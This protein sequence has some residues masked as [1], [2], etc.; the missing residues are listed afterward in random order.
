MTWSDV[1]PESTF[2]NAQLLHLMITADRSLVAY[3]WVDTDDDMG[4]LRVAAWES[5]AGDRWNEIGSGFPDQAWPAS[6]AQGAQ[7]HV[8]LVVEPEVPTQSL[9]WSPDG[10]TWERVR[11]LGSEGAYSVGA[12]DEGFV[13]AGWRN[14][15]SQQPYTVASGDGRSWFEAST[16]PGVAAGLVPRGGDWL[17]VS[18][19][20]AV[21]VG[22]PS[23]ARIWSSA[24]GLTWEQSGSFALESR[25]AGGAPCTEWPTALHAAGPWLIATTVVSYPCSEGGTQTQGT[26]R[27]SLDGIEWSPLPF[28][29]ASEEVGLGTRISGAVEVDGRLILVGEQDRM[30][31]FWV[32]EQP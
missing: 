30:A 1:T 23:T 8:A 31:S 18:R 28:A 5:S 29:P 9:W 24:N 12:G 15:S 10:R 16:P 3:G 2:T 27:I 26:Q 21:G 32:G 4:G 11:D 22:E 19:E 7:G 20:V 6:M 14:N 17:A 13:V 25:D